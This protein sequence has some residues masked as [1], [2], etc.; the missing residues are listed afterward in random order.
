[1]RLFFMKSAATFYPCHRP[2]SGLPSRVTIVVAFSELKNTGAAMKEI[3]GTLR[4]IIPG[5]VLGHNLLAR[6]GN[7]PLVLPV[8][9]S[10]S[11]PLE[12]RGLGGA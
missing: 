10:A 12:D 3:C 11:V 8:L 9:A 6:D 5:L 1:M 4:T 2:R 7:W